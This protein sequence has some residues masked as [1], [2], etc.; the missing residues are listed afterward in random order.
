MKGSIIPSFS[1]NHFCHFVV[2]SSSLFLICV[3]VVIVFQN[4]FQLAVAVALWGSERQVVSSEADPLTCVYHLPFPIFSVLIRILRK[5]LSACK[6]SSLCF[7]R[8]GV[9]GL[10]RL[11][12]AHIA[13]V[14]K[15]DGAPLSVFVC[16]ILRLSLFWFVISGHNYYP[17]GSLSASQ[18]TFFFR[19]QIY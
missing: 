16:L 19:S 12:F 15:L 2:T 14:P 4:L 3:C 7:S 18:L 11:L 1:D 10:L 5:V 6:D 13:E 17:L 8:E 9:N